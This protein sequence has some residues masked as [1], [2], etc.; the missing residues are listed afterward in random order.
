MIRLVER[1]PTAEEYIS[2]RLRSGMGTKG[3]MRSQIALNNSLFVVTIY[4]GE[5]LIAFGRVV[6]DGGITYVVSD[7]MVD[8]AY[9]RMG[10][11]EQIMQAIDRYFDVYAHEDSYICLIANRPADQLYHKHRFD[12]L[13]EDKCGMLRRQAKGDHDSAPSPCPGA[14]DSPRQ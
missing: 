3:I 1:T 13:P 9:R 11:A 14:C 4:D 5:T 6:G 7:I 2:L 8:K 10:L 12:Y